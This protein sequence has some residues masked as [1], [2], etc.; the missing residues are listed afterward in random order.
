MRQASLPAR[1]EAEARGIC[2][3]V[4]G[5][6]TQAMRA[7]GLLA[8]AAIRGNLVKVSSSRT[9]GGC[10]YGVD[11]PCAQSAHVRDIFRREGVQVR[12][13]LTGEG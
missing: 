2:T 9:R 5:S 11:F 7:Q 6:M 3:A 12:Q 10:A 13:Y 1:R 8:E 4:L